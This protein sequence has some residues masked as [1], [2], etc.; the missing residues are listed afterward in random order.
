MKVQVEII[1]MQKE[2]T[3]VN[4]ILPRRRFYMVVNC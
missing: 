4:E 1:E 2:M 3:L